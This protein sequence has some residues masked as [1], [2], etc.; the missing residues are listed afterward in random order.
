[1]FFQGQPGENGAVGLRGPP[2][3]EVGANSSIFKFYTV[4]YNIYEIIL[5]YTAEIVLSV[6]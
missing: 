1:M 4:Y 2:G 5:L 3:P 6:F